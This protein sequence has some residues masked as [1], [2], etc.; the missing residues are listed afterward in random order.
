MSTARQ[1]GFI[2][3]L[4]TLMPLSVRNVLICD[5][6]GL[7]GA[8]RA[9]NPMADLTGIGVTDPEGLDRLIEGDPAKLGKARLMS[10]DEDGYDLVVLNGTLGRLHD[11]EPVLRR[12]QSVMRPGGYLISCDRN[13]GHWTVLRDQLMGR[14][15]ERG[16]IGAE[17]LTAMLDGAG[18]NLRRMIARRD[19]PDLDGAKNWQERLMQL[20]TEAGLAPDRLRAR[21]SASHLI[22]V[23]ESSDTNGRLRPQ[24]RLHQIELA[25]NMDVRTRVPAAA[26]ASEPSVLLTMADARLVA[27][28]LGPA[29]GVVIV[30]RPRLSDASLLL[31][32]TAECQKRGIVMV[33]E[34]DDDPSLVARTLPR[35]DVPE[36]HD[37]NFA[38]SHAIQ[39]ST[40][41]LAQK[42]G[43]ANPEIRVFDNVAEDIL[44][45]REHDAGPVRVLFA[46]LNRS[47]TREIA[48]RL[49]PAIK[50]VPD[51]QFGVIHD[52]QFFDALPTDRKVYYPLLDYRKYMD[53]LS[54]SDIVLMPL[55]GLPDELG[56]SD[57][58]WVEA[59]S[60]SA[61]AIASPVVYERTIRDGENGFLARTPDDWSRL[62][63]ELAK[64][65]ELR[66][67]VAATARDEVIQ[68]RMMAGQVAERRNWYRSLM[69]RREELFTNAMARSPA[70]AE[71]VAKASA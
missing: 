44:P 19:P 38:L 5:G 70:L 69:A 63:V 41:V 61:V 37:Y 62:L 31:N 15:G 28:D 6:G 2:R 49:A 25:Q 56:K 55:E 29:G 68:H 60:R 47:G 48:A 24:L 32:F 7:A 30:Q 46:A 18:F 26:L 23:T 35:A 57:V 3:E 58:K 52:R 33:L 36:I 11:P 27:P 43:R 64:D 50:V 40:E 20:G 21:L 10:R 17:A 12:L 65:H 34:Y 45:L 53:A 67:R 71:A 22:C 66:S 51:V 9:R 4:L 16:V 8:Y 42:F 14:G 1:H 13:D 59:A 39:T 54:R